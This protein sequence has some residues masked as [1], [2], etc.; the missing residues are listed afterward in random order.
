M[1]LVVNVSEIYGTVKILLGL[2]LWNVFSCIWGLGR[3]DNEAEKIHGPF[4]AA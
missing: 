4:S 2:C 3:L 1:W